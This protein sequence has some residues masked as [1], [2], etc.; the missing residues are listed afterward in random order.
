MSHRITCHQ[1]SLQASDLETGKHFARNFGEK[2]LK[3]RDCGRVRLD[4]G[5]H[6]DHALELGA[7]GREGGEQG[8]EAP[9]RVTDD[10]QG[11]AGE[12]VYHLPAEL[13]HGP[14]ELLH[15]P[16]HHPL[17]LALPVTNMIEAKHQEV[18]A[19]PGLCQLRVVRHQVLCIAGGVIR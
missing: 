5:A 17:P 13:D 18:T 15:V 9:H 1:V 7:V 10:E 19:S 11:E 6:E 3:A 2:N 16:G 8:D 14:G 4:E 12:G